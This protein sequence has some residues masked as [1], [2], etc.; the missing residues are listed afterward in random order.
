MD[1]K[2][3]LHTA[4]RGRGVKEGSWHQCAESCGVEI[5][6]R[7][8]GKT[9]WSLE[10]PIATEL[11]KLSR[12]IDVLITREEFKDI[13]LS[14]QPFM[15]GLT[16]ST[17][18]PC[19]IFSAENANALL[20][21]Q[22]LVYKEHLL[23]SYP[24]VCFGKVVARDVP[25]VAAS[26]APP[27]QGRVVEAAV[28]AHYSSSL[29]SGQIALRGQSR[30]GSTP[31][32]LESPTH[33][34]NPSRIRLSPI[35]SLRP[36]ATGRRQSSPEEPRAS[37]TPHQTNSLRKTG[38]ADDYVEEK[39][40]L[41]EDDFGSTDEYESF[42]EE[43]DDDDGEWSGEHIVSA[44]R[45]SYIRAQRPSNRKLPHLHGLVEAGIN[46]STGS[47]ISGRTSGS[48]V[49]KGKQPAKR[50]LQTSTESSGL[51]G[52]N[53]NKRSR[54][55]LDD[56]GS[57]DKIKICHRKPLQRPKTFACPFFKLDLRRFS[58]CSTVC[59]REIKDV[60]QHLTRRHKAPIR[61][62]VCQGEFD[63]EEE[64]V[65]HSRG[66]GE[67][68]TGEPC[69]NK[70]ERVQNEEVTKDMEKLLSKRA[71][72][73]TTV[74]DQWYLVWDILFPGVAHPESPYFDLEL[75]VQTTEANRDL[76]Q[77]QE[78]LVIREAAITL[79]GVVSRWAESIPDQGG[80]STN[81]IQGIDQFLATVSEYISTFSEEPAAGSTRDQG[82][83]SWSNLL[84]PARNELTAD[85]GN[86]GPLQ[87]QSL[88][89][90]EQENN[91]HDRLGQAG[92]AAYTTQDQ[93]QLSSA[94]PG[95][96]HRHEQTVE[97]EDQAQVQHQTSAPTEQDNGQHG[98][99][100]LPHGSES[101]NPQQ[102][103][104]REVSENILDFSD[105]LDDSLFQQLNFNASWEA[106]QP[107]GLDAPGGSGE[108]TGATAAGAPAQSFTT[109]PGP[110]L[111]TGQAGDRYVRDSEDDP[112]HVRNEGV[113]KSP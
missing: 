84:Q 87:Q 58:N 36:A 23:D 92:P 91:Q 31:G 71:K 109:H 41:E 104:L 47:G 73:G 108:G 26:V 54:T 100:E 106:H 34:G 13:R 89:P 99:F 111:L 2:N 5:T 22:K 16:R 79:R 8:D 65:T 4:T 42:S 3:R 33:M 27:I 62:P 29:D 14:F 9:L 59:P 30:D 67:N 94:N 51:K 86:Q 1:E 60:K 50:S 21:V 96:S 6:T 20:R 43:D 45:D 28:N 97:T 80:D 85:E 105:I 113:T 93:R 70:R 75:Y 76:A 68:A 83:P 69:S 88:A 103:V 35:Q 61:C 24:P 52:A 110:N 63:S 39:T 112:G 38:T 98:Q 57:A 18:M 101:Y 12:Q 10:G 55:N 95:Q 77:R 56:T 7:K 37:D 46:I 32:K 40:E 102:D 82:Q 48:D 11:T 107:L 15:V 49:A 53:T 90:T 25:K 19:I 81:L 17:A 78:P 64:C 74:E 44:G 66:E 72:A